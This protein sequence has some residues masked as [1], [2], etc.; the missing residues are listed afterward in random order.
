MT[1]IENPLENNRFQAV[2]LRGHLRCCAAGMTHSKINR[3]RLLQAA[4]QIVGKKY[5]R[6]QYDQAV[7]DLNEWLGKN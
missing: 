7:E 6:G 5:K 1:T 3:T 4:G 2:V